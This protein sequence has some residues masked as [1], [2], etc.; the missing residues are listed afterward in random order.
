MTK[1]GF[2]IIGCGNIGPFHADAI[3]GIDEAE[4]KAVCDIAEEKAKDLAVKYHADSYS[5]YHLQIRDMIETIKCDSRPLVDGA[6]GRKAVE[7]ILAFY[8]SAKTGQ[9]VKLP[10]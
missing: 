6:E 5:D 8:K 3:S 10:L 7:I 9:V 4:L 2:G 1:L